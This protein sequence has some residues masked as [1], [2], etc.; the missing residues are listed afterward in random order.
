MITRVQTAQADAW[1]VHGLLRA[2]TRALRG[3]R[4]MASGLPHAQWNGGDV[5]APDPDLERARAFYEEHGVPWGVRVP[6]GIPWSAG[7]HLF[8]KRLMGLEASDFMPAPPVPGLRIRAA[9][10]SD[11]ET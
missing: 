9:E 2:G 11:F 5:T 1:E 8:R 10:T 6:V 4:C 7:R 3:I